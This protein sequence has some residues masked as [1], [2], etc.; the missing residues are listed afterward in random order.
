MSTIGLSNVPGALA[1]FMDQ[2]VLSGMKENSALMKWALGGVSSVALSRV[3][4]ILEK[5]TPILKPLGVMD[6]EG[7][8][9]IDTAAAFLE[10]AFEKQPELEIQIPVIGGSIT[11]DRE[12]GEALI[13][14]LKRYGG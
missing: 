11:F 2:R 13:S 9:N 12:D 5:Y 8:L 1:D 7:N 4:K 14:L 10:S 6:E 3:D